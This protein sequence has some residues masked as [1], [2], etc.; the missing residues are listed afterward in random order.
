[1][2]R[3]LTRIERIERIVGCGENQINQI[4]PLWKNILL[5]CAG[6]NNG[7]NR[8][9]GFLLLGIFNNGLNRLN[10]FYSSGGILPP[11]RPSYI[12]AIRGRN[13]LDVRGRPQNTLNTRKTIAERWT[14]TKNS[15]NTNFVCLPTS[16]NICAICGRLFSARGSVSSVRSVGISFLTQISLCT[17]VSVRRNLMRIERIREIR[18]R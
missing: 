4:N 8:L 13:I 15:N 17:D 7:L 12:R 9:N 14:N 1:M 18:V 11:P 2:R 6:M 5:G 10:G 16:V 3:N